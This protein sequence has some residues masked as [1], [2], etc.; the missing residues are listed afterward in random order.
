MAAFKDSGT[1]PV[2]MQFHIPLANVVEMHLIPVPLSAI[3]FNI[4]L[5]E[6]V[7]STAN[8]MCSFMQF[9]ISITDA[10]PAL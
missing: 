10:L 2:N 6:N 8:D 1:D 3:F 4:K 7:D 5:P 9:W